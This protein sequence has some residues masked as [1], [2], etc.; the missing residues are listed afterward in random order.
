[1]DQHDAVQ[2]FVVHMPEVLPLVMAADVPHL[3]E[4][5]PLRVRAVH[6]RLVEVHQGHLGLAPHRPFLIPNGVAGAAG[7]A[8]RAVRADEVDP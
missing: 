8:V 7:S 3:D 2:A 6:P 5:R 4:V 1:M